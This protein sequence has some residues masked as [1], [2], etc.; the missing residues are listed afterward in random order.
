MGGRELAVGEGGRGS[1]QGTPEQGPGRPNRTAG[2][3]APIR[4]RLRSRLAV[5]GA[6]SPRAAPAAIGRPGGPSPAAGPGSARSGRRPTAGPGPR[7]PAHPQQPAG[8][9]A[10][11][12]GP[13]VRAAPAAGWITFPLPLPDRGEA[14]P[15]GSSGVADRGSAGVRPRANRCIKGAKRTAR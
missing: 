10:R 14:D 3:P 7:P 9:P 8:I 12:D 4:S 2:C 1:P 6:G 5:E 13:A 15:S 11:P